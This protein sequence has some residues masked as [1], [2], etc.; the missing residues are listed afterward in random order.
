V[1]FLLHCHKLK[2]TRDIYMD[3]FTNIVNNF[4]AMTKHEQMKIILGEGHNSTG[5][6][7]HVDL[8]DS[9]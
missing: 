3:R 5:C 9:G 6:E 2:T 7:I 8:R 4:R 1:H